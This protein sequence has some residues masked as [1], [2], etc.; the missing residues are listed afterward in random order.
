MEEF[1]KANEDELVKAVCDIIKIKS[2]KEEQKEGMPFGEGPAKALQYA[3]QLAESFGLK[4]KNLDNYA[5]WTEIGTGDE[6]VGVLVHLDVVPEGSGWSHSPYGG[7]IFDGKIYGRG[8]IDNKGPAMTALFALKTL[9]DAGTVLNK[10]VRVIFGTDEESDFECMKYYK[11]HD[12]PITMGFSPDA[13]YPIINGEK[14]ILTFSFTTVF[15]NKKNGSGIKLLSLKGGTRPNMVPDYAEAEVLGDIDDVKDAVNAI[16]DEIG[17]NFDVIQEGDK[18]TIKSYGISAHA[19]TP[20]KG[21]NAVMLLVRLLA[22]INAGGPKASFIRFLD[23]KLGLETTGAGLGVDFKDEVSGP[24]TLN[25]GIADIGEKEGTVTV[26]I[27]YPIE[28]TGNEVICK[29]REHTPEHIQIV[30]IH[31]KEPHY[32]PEDNI[33]IQKL[34]KAYEKVTGEK[35]Y[36]FTIGGGTYAR[37][38]DNCV[39]F[40]PSFPDDEDLAHQKDEY[41]KID[42]L[43]KNLRIYTYV[44]K[45]LAQ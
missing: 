8:A 2:V 11:A 28:Y 31:N 1:I 20:E 22:N 43:F 16:G 13:A 7:E 36:C 10:R 29:I 17:G 39:A 5:G 41:I 9:K 12:E 26:N 24:L 34:K 44:L 3:L 30:D 19:S 18:I 14:G 15:E 42:N 40:G 21:K 4:T 23:D 27:R 32:V 45:E 33:L 25:V 37:M 38:F 6:I 35:S